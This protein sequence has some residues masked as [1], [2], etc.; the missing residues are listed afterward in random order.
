MPDTVPPAS[1]PVT[2]QIT[3]S[4]AGPAANKTIDDSQTQISPQVRSLQRLEYELNADLFRGTIL[5]PLDVRVAAQQVVTLQGF[6][7]LVEGNWL[8]EEHILT[9]ES[10]S[11]ATS[12]LVV[13]KTQDVSALYNA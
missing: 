2:Q 6:G 9:L 8:V 5:L 10:S 1:P 12:D 7:T 11:N 13:R 4:P 3:P